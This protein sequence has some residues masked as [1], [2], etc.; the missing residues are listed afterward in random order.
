MVDFP[1]RDPIL[2]SKSYQFMGDE[3]PYSLEFLSDGRLVALFADE[4]EQRNEGR[5]LE[6][7]SDVIFPLGLRIINP[8]DLSRSSG[9]V[10]KESIF[11]IYF[12][13]FQSRVFDG[14][15]GVGSDDS[16]FVHG[17]NEF[18]RYTTWQVNSRNFSSTEMNRT[19]IKTLED[20]LSVDHTFFRG[21]QICQVREF[22]GV[23]YVL[24]RESSRDERYMTRI[25]ALKDGEIYGVPTPESIRSV[26]ISYFNAW[27]SSGRIAVD[28]TGLYFKDTSTIARVPLCPTETDWREPTAIVNPQD[29]QRHCVVTAHAV[30]LGRMYAFMQLTG[31]DTACLMGYDTKTGEELHRV[32]LP[33]GVEI[34][35]PELSLAISQRGV[36]AL[37]DAQ[38]RKIYFYDL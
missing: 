38:S 6:E 21:M 1:V 15:L 4:D 3:V 17:V 22:E 27:N 23:Q 26:D 12:G 32:A 16:L 20:K 18:G 2:R 14:S 13:V 9:V 34:P 5:S 29:K 24:M 30:G 8:N 11:A 31:E 33:F 10:Y 25:V 28:E 7:D 37:G 35:H 19:I 36:L